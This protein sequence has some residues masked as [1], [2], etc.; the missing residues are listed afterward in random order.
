MLSTLKVFVAAFL[1]SLAVFST[2]AFLAS[3]PYPY[4]DY[5]ALYTLGATG[6]AEHYFPGD[7]V[8]ILPRTRMS[9]YVGV[10]NHMGTVQLVRVAFKILNETMVGP[11]Q[12]NNTPSARDSFYE[13][14]RLLVTNETWVLPVSW[15][16]LNATST[17]NATS[18][19]SLLFNG[20]VLGDNVE[21]E[22][23]YGLNYRIV[24]ELWVYDDVSGNFSYVWT[25]NGVARSAWNEVWF[26][27]TRTSIL[28]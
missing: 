5:F 21:T 24:I 14:T 27:M 6:T 7:Q 25:A 1:I 28:P 10:Y 12:L 17:E 26:N 8:D 19:H 16:V 3:V 22:A 13:I 4:D 2:V 18:I 11:N 20:Q 23:Q 9:W 15:S